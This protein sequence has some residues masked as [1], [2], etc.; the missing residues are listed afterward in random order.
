MRRHWVLGPLHRHC[1]R[2]HLRPES[3]EYIIM[4]P[5][6]I[7]KRSKYIL[8]AITMVTGFLSLLYI[9]IQGGSRSSLLS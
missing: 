6:P 2:L 3:T 9:E 4:T 7:V 5:H 8:L 1:I